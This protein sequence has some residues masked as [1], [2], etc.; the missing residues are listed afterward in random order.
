MQ[1]KI[2]LVFFPAHGARV[3]RQDDEDELERQLCE[4]KGA[5]EWFRLETGAEKCRD[6]I[7]CTA[8][9][10]PNKQMC[11]LHKQTLIAFQDIN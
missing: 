10:R 6:V 8:S 7:Q 5:G 11:V 3:K 2:S 4:D 9:V 1:I